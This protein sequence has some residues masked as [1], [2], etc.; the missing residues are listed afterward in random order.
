MRSCKVLALASVATLALGASVAV[1]EPFAEA[2]NSRTVTA[3]NHAGE[4]VQLR[5]GQSTGDGLTFSWKQVDFVG[6]TP[7]TP[8]AWYEPFSTS[9]NPEQVIW[10]PSG[11]WVPNEVAGEPDV[12]DADETAT[13]MWPVAFFP[14]GVTTV[15]LTVTDANNATAV[16][17]VVITVRDRRLFSYVSYYRPWASDLPLLTERIV[18]D[19]DALAGLEPGNGN[20]Q[21]ALSLAT[22]AKFYDEYCTSLRFYYLLDAETG[23]PNFSY[24]EAVVNDQYLRARQIQVEHHEG[25]AFYV[26]FGKGKKW[27]LRE[28]RTFEN[29]LDAAGIGEYDFEQGTARATPS[30]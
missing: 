5:G 24:Y 30:P 14:I 3:Y 12:W 21:T 29:A 20:F 26:Y 23:E 7:E 10:I 22:T 17:T 1:A 27:S 6:P 25:V 28:K 19:C 2:G 13:S 18:T 9:D 4:F 11:E 8:F 16:D 15:E